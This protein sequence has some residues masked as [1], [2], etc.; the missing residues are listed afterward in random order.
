[1]P[2]GGT[3][4]CS[5]VYDDRMHKKRCVQYLVSTTTAYSGKANGVWTASSLN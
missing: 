4:I 5:V 2:V 1:M 3:E